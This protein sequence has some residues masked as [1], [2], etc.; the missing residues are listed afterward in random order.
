[1]K[2]FASLVF[3]AILLLGFTAI[4]TA[5]IPERKIKDLQEEL[6]GIS[7]ASSSTRKRRACKSAI[8]EGEKILQEY[9]EAPGRFRI[10]A[11]IL[12]GQKQL[13]GLENTAR[14]QEALLETCALLAKAPDEFAEYRLEADLLLSERELSLKDA[15][16]EQRSQALAGL[17]ERYRGT[18]GDTKCLMIASQ[19]A[20]KLEDLELEKAIHRAMRERFPDHPQILEYQW[21]KLGV[22]R[23]EALF[24]GTILRKDGSE[25]RFPVDRMGHL[26]IVVFWSKGTEGYQTALR[27]IN[28]H[29]QLYPGQFD[30]YSF[31]L[32]GL[33]DFG[34]AILGGMGLDWNVMQ[35]PDG[36]KSQAFRTYGNY[37][38]SA[39]LVNAYGHALLVPRPDYGFGHNAEFNPYKV[40]P[41]RNPDPRYLAQLR[42]LFIGDF[43]LSS[44]VGKD[45][46]PT[47]IQECFPAAPFRFRMTK[48]EELAN[49]KRAAQLCQEAP[50]PGIL[51]HHIIALLGLW[52]LT[53]DCKYL[54]QAVAASKAALESGLSGGREI[55]PQFC[56]A[57]AS[58]RDGVDS[59]KVL[60]SFIGATGGK[61]APGLAIAAAS[62]LALVGQSREL[63][64]HY[65]K[66]LLDNHT[67]ED[68]V[69]PVVGFLRDRYHSLD[70]L[71]PKV[72][73]GERTS[74]ANYG[75]TVSA[76]EHIVN[77]TLVKLDYPFPKL[78]LKLLDGSLLHLP[79]EPGKKL[80]YV[81][82]IEPP[83]DPAEE[84]PQLIG[85]VPPEGKK[86][87]QPGVMQFAF[88]RAELHIRKEIEVVAAFLADDVARIQ[89]MSDKHQW[90]CTVAT[91]PGGLNNPVVR[92]L[93]ILSADRIPNVFLIR[94]DGTV[95]WSCSGFDL[96]R[97]FGYPF[98]LK[99][100]M[101]L[102][103][104]VCD[105]E[106]AYQAL[107][108]G[109]FQ[110]A[111]DFFSGPF[112]LEND[113]RYAWR[114][115]RFHGRA[116][117]N[118]GL[119]DWEAALADVDTAI[120]AHKKDFRSHK[121]EPCGSMLKLL[122]IR[123]ALL[124]KLGRAGEATEVGKV[125][126]YPLTVY[127]LFHSRLTN[128]GIYTSP[129]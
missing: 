104:E 63:H 38:P 55:I 74:R 27:Q 5:T 53:A 66:L 107:S 1:M 41:V 106:Q 93:G 18:P 56:L 92:Q 91:V 9:P 128:L 78:E 50:G 98:A 83:A 65:R 60:S 44:K 6:D 48:E 13:L 68:A 4:A 64:N 82:F 102:H 29:Q 125:T 95:A 75:D 25:L 22:S 70:L 7:E 61:D 10:K 45:T 46:V 117:A 100:A 84:L 19:I 115:P 103:P 37:E 3:S 116:L 120:E 85:G 79:G 52:N 123:A 47:A 72:S 86:N 34:E 24:R 67:G 76:R 14:N 112:L 73:R 59:G 121:S 127:D 129:E 57:K 101:K 51:G 31:N 11:M 58:L 40:D 12:D 77:H 96:K 62:I 113:E 105:T 20:P 8:R 109:D 124:A 17:V 28:E 110:R 49:Y 39:I 94:R 108:K 15:S 21:K 81:L 16:L 43:L 54:E 119:K 88:E 36:K 69:W 126:S 97:D 2:P 35:L 118:I 114:A 42:A 111:K 89:A 122:R 23:I 33:P 71:Q 26:S 30:F 99:L 87:G 32:D 80:T 90:P